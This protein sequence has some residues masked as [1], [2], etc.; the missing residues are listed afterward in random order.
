MQDYGTQVISYRSGRTF[1]QDGEAKGTRQGNR[2]TGFSDNTLCR[3][4]AV[5][6]QYHAG[7][8]CGEC[9]GARETMPFIYHALKGAEAAL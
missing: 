8:S 7:G 3:A 9:W 1:N 6:L 4:K 2:D 5:Q